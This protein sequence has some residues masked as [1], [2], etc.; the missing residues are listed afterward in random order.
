MT[1]QQDR[2]DSDRPPE[3]LGRYAD[4]AAEL[5]R[6]TMGVTERALAQ[7]VR[8]GEVAAERAERLV[9]EVIARSVEGSGALA[10]QVRA[11]VERAI[12]RAGFARA[13]E[14]EALRR[15]VEVLRDR[16]AVRDDGPGAP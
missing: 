9:E 8:Q 10:Q 2:P 4:L 12:E 14:V 3:G 13:D 6:T 16:L 1:T 7:F 5:T 11:E 15:E